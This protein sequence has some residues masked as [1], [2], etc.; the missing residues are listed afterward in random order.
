MRYVVDLSIRYKPL[1]GQGV[2]PIFRTAHAQNRSRQLTNNASPLDIV[3][4]TAHSAALDSVPRQLIDTSPCASMRLDQDGS[5][6]PNPIDFWHSLP[7]QVRNNQTSEPNASSSY[8]QSPTRHR[9]LSC[10]AVRASR[11]G[12]ASFCIFV[13]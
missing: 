10:F 4:S 11:F 12:R 5:K 2:S 8:V 3:L 1:A 7:F 13:S 9:V 6:W